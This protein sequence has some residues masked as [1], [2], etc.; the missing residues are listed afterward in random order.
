[1]RPKSMYMVGV[2]TKQLG[3]YA[4]D[5]VEWIIDL[6]DYAVN[7]KIEDIDVGKW[8]SCHWTLRC[9]TH[10]STWLSLS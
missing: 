8:D 9:S 10:D 2:G 7:R 5:H 4:E 3:I 1:M 6:R